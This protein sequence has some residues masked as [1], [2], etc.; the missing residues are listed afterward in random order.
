[1]T[2][3]EA[4]ALSSSPKGTRTAALRNVG[5]AHSQQG[6]EMG[7]A[8]PGCNALLQGVS[9]YHTNIALRFGDNYYNRRQEGVVEVVMDKLR[10]AGNGVNTLNYARNTASSAPLVNFHLSG[11]PNP[12]IHVGSINNPCYNDLRL[13]GLVEEP[14]ANATSPTISPQVTAASLLYYCLLYTSPSP[15]DS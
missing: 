14:N 11:T 2:T 4:I 10:L 3:H 15:R 6:V 13:S 9:I 5:I 1:M 8:G 12:N 7:Y